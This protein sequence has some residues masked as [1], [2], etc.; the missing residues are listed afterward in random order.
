[1]LR[2]SSLDFATV[3]RYALSN[4]KDMMACDF[5]LSKTF[6]FLNSYYAGHVA[7]FSVE[8]ERLITLS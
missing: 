1:M 5:D 4:I 3:D 2:D 8:F 7:R 6:I